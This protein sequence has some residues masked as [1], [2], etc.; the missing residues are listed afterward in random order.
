VGRASLARCRHA[1]RK[2]PREAENIG[3]LAEGGAADVIGDSLTVGGDLKPALTVAATVGRLHLQSALLERVLGCR[4]PQVSEFKRA[5]A[6]A[7]PGYLRR[8]VTEISGLG[9]AADAQRH[10]HDGE[11]DTQR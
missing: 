9:A 8:R 2:R 4:T 10:E 7:P 3:Q 1:S 6:F 5:L 11:C